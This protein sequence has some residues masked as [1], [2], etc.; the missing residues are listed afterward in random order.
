MDNLNSPAK[1]FLN[2]SWFYI[3]YKKQILAKLFILLKNIYKNGI[4]RFLD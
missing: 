1:N 4:W 2:I 3:A